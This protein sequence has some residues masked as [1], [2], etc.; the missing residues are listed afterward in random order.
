[1]LDSNEIFFCR[2]RIFVPWVCTNILFHTMQIFFCS[3][4][5]IHHPEIKVVSVSKREKKL[6]WYR[7]Y[8][9]S[10]LNINTYYFKKLHKFTLLL[11]TRPPLIATSLPWDSTICYDAIIS[12]IV[13]VSLCSL[14]CDVDL[15]LS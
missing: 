6:R 11:N 13:L 3:S 2:K 4:Q 14:L 9:P 15:I 5:L 12:P 10:D 7:H 8:C 1:M